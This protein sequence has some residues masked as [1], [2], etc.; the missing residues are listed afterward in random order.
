MKDWRRVAICPGASL[1]D[2]LKTIDQGVMQVALV[3]ENE[4]QLLGTVTDG[5]IRRALLRGESLDTTVENAM[6]PNPV[7]GLVDEDHFIWQRTMLRH[8]LQHLPIL[9]MGG[10]VVGLVR[11]IQP[12]EPD[13]SNP[14]ILM[15]GGMGTRLHPLTQEQPK[16]LLQVGSKPI[17]ETIIENFRAQGFWN[18]HLCINYK[19]SM[20]RD[21]FG[22]GSR[23]D[24]QIRYVEEKQRMGTA[25]ALSLLEDLPELPFLVMNGDLLTNVDFVRLLNF[26][27]K[28]SALATMC[29]RDYRLQVPYGVIE[30][31]NYMISRLV[32]KPVEQ[33]F[34]N[35]GIYVLSPS[36][37]QY[38]P[39][40]NFYDMTTLMETLIAGDKR[41]SGFPL[42]DYWID[43]GEM[44]DYQRAHTEYDDYF[45]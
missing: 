37:M 6:N 33:Y 19:G 27:E 34:V 4:C 15:A 10:C 23:W 38:I 11:Y 29:V 36:V 3:I 17:L 30:L 40:G 20:I 24:V 18:I 39:H 41:V 21:Y 9:D 44:D 1:R 8:N 43:I 45:A 22:D 26:H 42:R 2:A 7:T 31:D 12:Q 25:G 35:A 28:Q 14:V 5:D 13:R 16:P 32:E